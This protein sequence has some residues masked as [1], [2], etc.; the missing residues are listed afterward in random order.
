MGRFGS[1][2]HKNEGSKCMTS[3]WPIRRCGTCYPC[4]N[5]PDQLDTDC[6]PSDEPFDTDTQGDVEE[7]ALV[8]YLQRQRE[9]ERRSAHNARNAR[10]MQRVQRIVAHRATDGKESCHRAREYADRLGHPVL[11]LLVYASDTTWTY[12]HVASAHELTRKRTILNDRF[13]NTAVPLASV[14][15]TDYLAREQKRKKKERMDQ[16]TRD[17]FA[18]RCYACYYHMAGPH[19]H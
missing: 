5:G 9:S 11:L 14:L 15:P 7:A 12:H 19:P 4:T 18:N 2:I 10:H 17:F 3:S 8:S 1:R 6:T 13:W 16:W